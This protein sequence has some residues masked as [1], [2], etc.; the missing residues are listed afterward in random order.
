MNQSPERLWW[1]TAPK[2]VGPIM[3]VVCFLAGVVLVS[4][5]FAKGTIDEAIL[6]CL[7]ALVLLL[8]GVVDLLAELIAITLRIDKS[9]ESNR[10]DS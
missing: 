6:T 5:F 9:L 1:A 10:I 3:L 4:L 2:H 8:M 7:G